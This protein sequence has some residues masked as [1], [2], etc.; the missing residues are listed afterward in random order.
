MIITTETGG[1]KC[2][3]CGEYGRLGIV[4]EYGDDLAAEYECRACGTVFYEVYSYEYTEY[5]REA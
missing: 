2:P 1:G 4:E 5:E 3:R